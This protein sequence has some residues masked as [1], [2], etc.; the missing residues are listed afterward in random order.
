MMRTFALAAGGHAAN[1]VAALYEAE[2]AEGEGQSSV[3][4]KPF[5]NAELKVYESLA[6]THASD[7]VHAVVPTF[8][9]VQEEPAKFLRLGNLLQGFSRPKV[10]DVKLGK[11]TFLHSE[12][13]N[14]KPR[15]DL[16]H[17][18]LE[19]FPSELTAAERGMQMVTKSRYMSCRDAKSTSG[20]FGYRVSG[21]AG[22]YR[23]RTRS[24]V[25]ETQGDT[26]HAFRIFAKSIESSSGNEK[27]TELDSAQ[28]ADRFVEELNALRSRLEASP[29]VRHHECIGTS[30]LL[31]ADGETGRCRVFWIDFAKTSPCD[32]QEGLSHRSPLS[33]ASQEEGLLTGL[34]NLV[35][36][37]E[38]VASSLRT[39]PI[40]EETSPNC[41]K[42]I[43]SGQNSSLQ[44][45]FQNV[46][47]LLLARAS[48]WRIMVDACAKR[49]SVLLDA[50]LKKKSTSPL[51][52][53]N[54]T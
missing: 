18:M 33:S 20:V 23:G 39:E 50:V 46:R 16:F 27:G 47:A 34:D 7:P 26:H 10:M 48:T 36:A 41:C 52:G 6:S 9:G 5:D 13:K 29:F 53:G 1:G 17:K 19:D 37:W 49:E 28:I 25:S 42:A 32:D 31:V 15:V 38:S 8:H 43:F 54:T 12:T 4:L 24:S 30:A 22:C 21:T 45:R 44:K 2:C 35:A 3:L 11:R 14:V 51:L 40:A